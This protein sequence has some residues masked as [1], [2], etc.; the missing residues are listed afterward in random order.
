VRIHRIVAV[1]LAALLI[2]SVPSPAPA[3]TTASAPAD[4]APV[5]PPRTATLATGDRLELLPRPTGEGVNFRVVPVPGREPGGYAFASVDGTLRVQPLAPTRS[6]KAT[7]LRVGP[8]APRAAAPAQ[9]FPVKLTIATPNGVPFKSMYVWDRA[10]WTYYNPVDEEFTPNASVEL[11]SGSY[12][13]VALYFGPLGS[14][15]LVRTFTIT[16]A[17]MTVRFEESSARETRI[18]VDDPSARR[19]DA[20]AWI[21]VPNGPGGLNAVAGFAGRGPTGRMFVT[22]FSA[23]SASLRLHE[24]LVADG[25]S[26]FV[27]SPFRYDLYHEF[28]TTVPATPVAQV[29]RAGLARTTTSIRAQALMTDGRLMAVPLTNDWTGVFLES[30]ITIPGTVTEYVTPDLWFLRLLTYGVN[31][32]Y[33]GQRDRLLP[34]GTSAGETVGIAPFAPRRSSGGSS[35]REGDRITIWE[36]SFVDAAGNGGNDFGSSASIRLADQFDNTIVAA[37]GL[38]PDASVSAPGLP[39]EPR[40]YKLDYRVTRAALWSR[41]SPELRSEWTF[42]SASTTQ[43][44]PLALVDLDFAVS[45]LDARNTARAG[46]VRID[47]ATM[48]RTVATE[49]ITG[50]E[51]STDDGRTW[52]ALAF[53]GTGDR[54]SAQLAVPPTV[55]F[56]S[57][58]A[59]AADS[60][61]G[62]VRRT[63]L[64]A[65]AG[66]G[67]DRDEKSR[68]L[69]VMGT[70]VNGGRPIAV[71]TGPRE[72]TVRF[73]A[74]GGLAIAG[75]AVYLYHG[76]YAA[77]D[78]IILSGGW[79]PTCTAGRLDPSTFVSS[80][81][82]TFVVDP[83]LSFGPNGL[84][85]DWKVAVR[86]FD[87]GGQSLADLHAIGTATFTRAA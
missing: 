69:A 59:T 15:L 33:M 9:T 27:P 53:S 22:P 64:R 86:A 83:R 61:G 49:S 31:A 13:A 2:A 76:S 54:A 23:A 58:R 67:S 43:P 1:T 84:P 65:F 30:P 74:R 52:T 8:S 26:D 11:P 60:V 5:A 80:C 25:A 44:S 3:G 82:E 28:T 12:F 87:A 48:S 75:A 70:V 81:T 47:L 85:G 51:Y 10:T 72:F 62:T 21:S 50:L 46:S 38:R 20:L 57:L 24:V 40:L 77:P 17:G 66:P 79:P 55:A 71:G 7:E 35:G 14:Y 36:P 68:P 19:I 16:N 29:A 4:P 34:A 73:V 78:G 56:V 39:P 32:Q 42:T 63:V 45:D 6:F 41:L 18:A 37:T